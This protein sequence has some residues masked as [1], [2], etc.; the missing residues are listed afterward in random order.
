ME[1]KKKKGSFQF[2][3]PTIR[4]QRYTRRNTAPLSPFVFSACYAY[5]VLYCSQPPN[6]KSKEQPA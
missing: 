3:L 2:C 5:I 1:G 4:F 6:R